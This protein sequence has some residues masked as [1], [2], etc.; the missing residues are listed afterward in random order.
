MEALA[1][2]TRA[3]A[4]RSA[5]AERLWDASRIEFSSR[6]YHGARVQG[7]AR[8][9]ACNVALLYRHW[10][11][12]RALY[13]DILGGAWRSVFGEVLALIEQEK[14]APGVVSALLDA[15][16][17][18]PVGA[19]IVIREVLDGGPFLSQLVELDP[20][21]SEP[22]RRTALA[23]GGG[24]S[25]ARLRPG[26]DATVAVLSICG[27]AAVVACVHAASRPF[28]PSPM[29]TDEWREHAFRL[30]LNGVLEPGGAI[31]SQPT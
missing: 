26:V 10:A 31:A 13:L 16:L 29:S 12:K 7:I 28:F 2:G 21:L 5:I 14:V 1:Q 17:K 25:P 3:P 20:S 30:L 19:Q 8:R 11:S 27:L 24:E 18:D 4:T 6:G 22:I 9:A 23:L 15:N